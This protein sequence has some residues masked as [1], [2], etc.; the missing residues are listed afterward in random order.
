MAYRLLAD[1]VVLLHLAFVLFVVLGGLLVLRRPRLAWF[2]LPA[3]IWGAWVETS[4]WICRETHRL[5]WIEMG[6]RILACEAEGQCLA[7][8]RRV[9]Q[10]SNGLRTPRP[11]RLSTCV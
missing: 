5:R 10:M 7:A 4:G 3:A 6:N 9:G 8:F 11:P 2:H 1:L